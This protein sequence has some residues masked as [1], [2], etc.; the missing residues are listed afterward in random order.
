MIDY[1]CYIGQWPFHKLRRYTFEDLKAVHRKNGIE[2]GY[3]SSIYSIFYND[4]YESEKELH[5]E[6]K[7]S[8]YKQIVTVN[9]TLDGCMYILKRCVEDFDVSGIRL[10]PCYHG[11]NINSK[12]LMPVLS[13]AKENNL[14]IFLTARMLDE[15]LAHIIYP[16]LMKPDD[17]AKFIER[18]VDTKIILCHFKDGEISEIKDVLINEDFVYTDVSGFSANI[19]IDNPEWYKKA[20]FGS[21]FPLKNVKSAVLRIETELRDTFVKKEMWE[22]VL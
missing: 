19:V 10:I 7:G 20:V 15:R 9:P 8:N 16:I 2:Y 17:V 5:E 14:P 11:Y 6:I 1:N 21:G 12:V 22:D 4:F 3:L 13:F 18:N